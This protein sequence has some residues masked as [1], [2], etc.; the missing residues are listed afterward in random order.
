M[1]R[2]NQTEPATFPILSCLAFFG[3]SVF[4]YFS[5]HTTKEIP[6]LALL[7]APLNLS[8]VQLLFRN[9]YAILICTI[10]IANYFSTLHFFKY[11]REIYFSLSGE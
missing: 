6:K 3:D 10:S 2:L 5:R 7:L 9:K 8:D 1:N 4:I 11:V